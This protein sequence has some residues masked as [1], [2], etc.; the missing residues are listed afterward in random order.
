MDTMRLLQR[1]YHADY[2]RHDLDLSTLST[3]DFG[4]KGDNNE[5]NNNEARAKG[6]FQTVQY[7]KEAFD[8]AQL[9]DRIIYD[10]SS[11]YPS[12]GKV[13]WRQILLEVGL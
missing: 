5:G 3:P 8:F 12:H 7:L 10:M 13:Q 11:A 2:R 6:T 4:N 9:H 1:W